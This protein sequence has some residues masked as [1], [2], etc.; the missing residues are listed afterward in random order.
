MV[1]VACI[2]ELGID[3]NTVRRFLNTT[4]KDVSNIEIA[5]YLPDVYGFPLVFENRVAGRY[6]K[7]AE[8]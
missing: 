3:A 1:A 5:A 4:L 6:G 7:P 8:L 2:D